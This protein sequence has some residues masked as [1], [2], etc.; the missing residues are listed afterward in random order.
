M[1]KP[2]KIWVICKLYD[3]ADIGETIENILFAVTSKELADFCIKHLE[4][5]IKYSDEWFESYE[6]ELWGD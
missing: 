2:K 5:T 4:K 1:V 3:D 6:I